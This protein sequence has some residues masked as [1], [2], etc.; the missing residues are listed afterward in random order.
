[1][2]K[3]HH[4][5]NRLERL[6]LAKKNEVDKLDAKIHAEERA[7]KVWKKLSEESLKEWETRYELHL[8][9]RGEQ[10]PH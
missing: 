7:S 3:K 4:P 10:K 6:K 5:H 9:T 1:M 8:A 2:S